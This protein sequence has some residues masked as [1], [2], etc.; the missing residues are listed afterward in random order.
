MDESF[1]LQP[2]NT[3]LK[4]LESTNEMESFGCPKCGYRE[5]RSWGELTEEERMVVLRLPASAEFTAEER[6]KHRFCP[7][8]WF[9][10]AGGS[11]IA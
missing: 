3:K 11:A 6:K 5:M 2:E 8:C 9:E 1:A 4:Q 7:R 10:E